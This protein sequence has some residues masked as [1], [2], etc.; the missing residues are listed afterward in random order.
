MKIRIT[1]YF[2]PGPIAAVLLCSLTVLA[3][4]SIITVTNTNDSGPGSLRQALSV[5]NDGDTIDFAVTGTITLT[6]GELP[7][8]DSIT[9]SGPGAANLAVDGNT[10]NRVFHVGP[11]KTV[12]I[13]ALT[14]IN[15]NANGEF[16]PDDSGGGVYNDHA[17]VTLSE[18]AINSNSAFTFGGGVFNDHATVT[19]NNC[20]LNDNFADNTGGALYSDGSSGSA[21]AIINGS[22]LTAN[23]AFGGGAIYNN[24]ESGTATLDITTS[25]LN[26]NFAIADG[27]AIY[28]DHGDVTLNSCTISG[29]SATG[30]GGGG[31]FNLGDGLG[32]A[33]VE[34]SSSTLSNN[35]S[36]FN[37]GAIYSI[38]DNGTANVQVLNSTISANIASNFGG[39]VYNH[40]TLGN[41]TVQI[42]NSTFA[43]NVAKSFGESIYNFDQFGMGDA[44]AT[45]ANT[46]F[47]HNVTGN[48]VND[49]GT[50]TSFGYNISSD[51]AG[52]Y[53]TGPG[54]QINTDPML[55]QLQNNGGPTFTH[56]LLPGSP[57]IDTGDPSFTPPPFYDQRGSG[58]P[59]V[60][61]GRIDKGS[62]EV[63]TGGTPTPTPTATATTTPS[64]SAT[65][66]ATSTPSTTPRA[67]PT[68]R[69]RPTPA[70]RP[71][72]LI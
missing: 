51:N 71:T 20:T 10:D 6:T 3:S 44:I 69:P 46:I 11:G 61:N 48:F 27:A 17:A 36:G 56:A 40:G 58:Y 37:G 18:C 70:R 59:R 50:M 52:G 53:L 16:F 57:A 19:L 8:N 68:P 33:T 64:P 67:T 9:I 54:D 66:T 63:Q 60:V 26:G 45:F 43:E 13:S 39:G 12:T 49:G 34:I 28:N 4:A 21:N 72:A 32:T 1:S 41:A 24:G 23:F 62:V 5:A 2:R 31:I 22:A 65:P 42:A 25:A 35:E 29:N 30:N 38:G 14:I 55:G 47:K 15:G 7:V